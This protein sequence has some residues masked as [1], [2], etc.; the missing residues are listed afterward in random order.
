ML[1][2][3]GG[4]TYLRVLA[5]FGAT[6]FTLTLADGT[7]V[8]GGTDDEL[9]LTAPGRVQRPAEPQLHGQRSGVRRGT[10]ATLIA[11]TVV[12]P[13]PPSGVERPGGDRRHLGHMRGHRPELPAQGRGASS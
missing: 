1:S 7:P 6:G 8:G 12:N 5:P 11:G 10:I 9:T 13:N 2:P 4:I 3:P